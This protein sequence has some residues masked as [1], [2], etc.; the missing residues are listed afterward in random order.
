M[1]EVFTVIQLHFPFL[2][3]Y[4]VGEAKVL[5]LEPRILFYDSP[6]GLTTWRKIVLH[7]VGQTHAFYKVV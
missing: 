7:N 4:K 3:Y 1:K 6:Q 5:F 2:L